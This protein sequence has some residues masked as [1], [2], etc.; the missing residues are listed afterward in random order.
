VARSLLVELYAVHDGQNN[1]ALYLSIRD[2]ARRVGV[3]A[4]T[5]LRGFRDLECRGF[6]RPN[7]RGS[8]S[9]KARHATTWVLTEFGHAAGCRPRSSCDG[10]TRV[11]FRT[12]SQILRPTV[13]MVATETRLREPE[14]GLTVSTI[15]TV[16]AVFEPSRYQ[17]LRHN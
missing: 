8:F 4:N 9:W 12:R 17:I 6:I 7:Q 15:A 14:S 13:S 3:A 16:A 5:V 2:A 1:G 10:R 11:K